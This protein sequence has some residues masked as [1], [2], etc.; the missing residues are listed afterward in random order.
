[1]PN[2]SI[3][4]PE[5]NSATIRPALIDI[6]SQVKDITRIPK[7]ARISFVGELEAAYQKGSLM[8][9]TNNEGID[10][11]FSDKVTIEVSSEFNESNV[12]STAVKQAEHAPVFN[13]PA[14]GVMVKPIYGKMDFTINVIF[15]S[16]S[17]TEGMNWRNA[18]KTH[19]S[20]MRDVN[21]HDIT[22]HFLIPKEY[23]YILT[24]IHRLREN[25]DP[26][27]DDLETYLSTHSTTR[28][29]ALSNQSGSQRELGVAEKQI[30]ILGLYDFNISP[31]KG[32]R[33]EAGSAWLT[34][35]AYKVS[36]D[37]PMKINMVYPIMVHNQLLTYPYISDE[38][39]YDLDNVDKRYSLSIGL[40]SHFES[41]VETDKAMERS[42]IVRIPVFDEFV[43]TSRP[44]ATQPMFSALC[45]VDEQNKK[46]LLNLRELGDFQ[47]DADVIKYLEEEYSYL[48]LPYKSIFHL[49]L[50][51]W[52]ALSTDKRI[53]VDSQLNV[54]AR[55]DL[56][57][58][59]NHRVVFSAITD[60]SMIDIASLKR[61]KKHKAAA[62]KVLKAIGVNKAALKYIAHRVNFMPL[63]PD[64]PDTG[65]DLPTYHRQLYQF[66]TVQ[67]GYIISRDGFSS[68][69]IEDAPR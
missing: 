6:I 20:M 48:T 60:I 2:I 66:N 59:V 33:D 44:H 29:T 19:I 28:M 9:Q 18:I 22:Y 53:Y 69:R 43:P 40:L 42:K 63:L 24:E 32:N 1:M 64:L 49:S 5:V 57:L 41:N 8:T 55:E 65:T 12:L 17:Q 7:D 27:G 37:I 23:T 13:D 50:Y 14:I 54:M 35:F 30:R 56:S 68:G 39:S 38:K 15:R 58:R 51:K 21:L 67:T 52:S 16:E 62:F 36:F 47:L 11:P 46:L 61:L 25:V 3:P 4:T 45:S 26:Y 10:L 31:E 34:T